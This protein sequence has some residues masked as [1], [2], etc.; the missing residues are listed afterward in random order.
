MN[1][2]KR[3][4]K[5]WKN[6]KAFHKGLEN[7]GFVTKSSSQIIPIMIGNEKKA[8][9]FGKFLMKNG[10]YVQPIRYP[11]VPKNQARLRISEVLDLSGA[12]SI[13]SPSPIKRGPINFAP[14]YSFIN[15]VEIAALCS[16]GIIKILA[17]PTILE[18][19]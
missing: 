12:T 7:I 4:K 17:L 10:I 1:R 11:T 3:R 8:M 16:A 2:E 6:I 19:G 9:D 5:L 14:P 13:G 15:L 18:K